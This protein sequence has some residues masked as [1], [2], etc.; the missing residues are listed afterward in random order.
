MTFCK[1]SIY[2][3]FAKWNNE[4]SNGNYVISVTKPPFWISLKS[5]KA[6]KIVSKMIKMSQERVKVAIKML[7]PWTSSNVQ[8]NVS[9]QNLQDEVEESA[10]NF[11]LNSNT[12][13]Y[14]ES[15]NV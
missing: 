3:R 1:P 12:Y 5:Q 15:M 10:Q 13:I 9:F 7:M 14:K 6:V 8:N 2:F 11:V 4:V